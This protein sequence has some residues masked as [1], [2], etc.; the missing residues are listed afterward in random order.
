VASRAPVIAFSFCGSW[1]RFFFSKNNR[2]WRTAALGRK[3]TF[4]LALSR[5]GRFILSNTSMFIVRESKSDR[6]V[7][8]PEECHEPVG[9]WPCP[10]D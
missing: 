3:K 4:S 9:G 6:R 8:N 7:S 5:E 10:S 2:C 1:A